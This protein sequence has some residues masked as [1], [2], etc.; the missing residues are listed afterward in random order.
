VNGGGSDLIFPHHECGAAHAEAH[1]GVHPFAKHYVHAGMIGLDGEKMSK[2]RGNLVFVSKLRSQGVDPN[3]IRL[4][5]LA[6]HYRSDRPWTAD[7]LTDA[8]ERLGRGG[9]RSRATPARTG[10]P[11]SPRCATGW[12]TT[13]TPPARSRPSTP[14]RRGRATTRRRRGWSATRSTPCSGSRLAR[15]GSTAGVALSLARTQVRSALDQRIRTR[16]A[17]LCGPCHVRPGGSV[18]RLEPPVV[19]VTSRLGLDALDLLPVGRVADDL[20]DVGVPGGAADRW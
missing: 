13:S 7:L 18:R 16:T 8:Q 19:T 11:S 15:P 1:T 17:D 12:P 2:S 10:P 14:G 20:V 6:G 4:A 9:P 3:A 5:L